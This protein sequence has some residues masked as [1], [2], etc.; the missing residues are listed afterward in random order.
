MFRLVKQFK[1]IVLCFSIITFSFIGYAVSGGPLHEAAKTGNLDEVT[2]LIEKGAT[3]DV[4]D[5]NGNTALYI[6]VGQGH[7]EVAQLLIM[8]GANVNAV[9]WLG[10]TPLHWAVTV[11]GG[12]TDLAELLITKGANVNAVD[13]KGW[14]PLAKAA[15]SGFIDLAE[16]LISK[17]ANVNIDYP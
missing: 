15:Y 8:K 9:C 4:K 10:Y 3:V 16:L 2:G 6:A 14:T 17:G 11:L 12:K 5:E 13:N 7:K 1:P